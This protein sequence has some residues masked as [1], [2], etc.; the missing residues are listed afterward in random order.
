MSVTLMTALFLQLVAV[1]ALRHLLGK[2][3]LR[4]PVTL[5]ILASAVY[6]GVSPVLLSFGSIGTWD[7]YRRG[8][9]QQYVDQATLILSGAML[10]F[11]ACY[12][13]TRPQR[14]MAE[15]EPAD[16]RVA[17]RMLDWRLLALACVPLAVLTYS[18]RGY[19][20]GGSPGATTSLSSSL[21][22]TF[23]VIMVVV[24]A[25][26]FLLRH[27]TRLFLPILAAQS[28]LLA[29]AGERTPIL[30]DAIALLALLASAGRRPT[31]MQVRVAVALTAVAILAITGVRA[32]QGR[33]IYY[34]DS[35]LGARVTALAGG[36]GAL[37]GTSPQ[38]TP[39]LVAQAAVRLDGTD[40][41]GAIVQAEHLGQPR[42]GAAAVPES[43]LLAV[44]SALWPSKLAHDLNPVQ[45]ELDGFAMQQVNFLPGLPGLYSGFLPPLWLIVL[46][47]FL[48]VL[49]GR[50]ERWLLSQWTTAR[51]VLLAGAVTAALR[52]EQGLPGMLLALRA[53]V[54]IAV[55]VKVAEM[56]MAR[57]QADAVRRPARAWRNA[58]HARQEG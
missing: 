52:F 30:I 47:G 3:W 43:V 29:A 21:A 14:V 54:V 20:G 12:L 4:R 44:P 7:I 28:L 41:A 8:V 36:L 55:V 51:A 17:A 42:L 25:F 31:G 46:L 11:T 39:G 23:F 58:L 45:A 34:R 53:A 26:S 18:G 37:R 9:Q 22:S 57:R 24:A 15:P 32:E 16:V 48:G 50:G 27:D 38:G 40:F 35:G 6:Q 13:L 33:S 1:L 19:N 5:L 49:A 56:A 10:A 2:T